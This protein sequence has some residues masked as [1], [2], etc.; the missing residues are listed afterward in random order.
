[1]SHY[2]KDKDDDNL[3]EDN[4]DIY[5]HDSPEEIQQCLNC[6][7]KTCTNCLGWKHDK[8]YR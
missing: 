1:M 2:V 6:K 4:I 5:L 7:K 3:Q 8:K